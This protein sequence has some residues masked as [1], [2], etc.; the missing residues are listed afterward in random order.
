LFKRYSGLIPLG[1]SV[2]LT[3]LYLFPEAMWGSKAPVIGL[4]LVSSACYVGLLPFPWVGLLLRVGLCV[5]TL[6]YLK[7]QS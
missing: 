7:V 1:A 5:F 2:I 4:L 3:F 6:L